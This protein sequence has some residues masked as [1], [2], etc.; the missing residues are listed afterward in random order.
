MKATTIILLPPIMWCNAINHKGAGNQ[1]LEHILDNK[2]RCPRNKK[3]RLYF[4]KV[5]EGACFLSEKSERH[6]KCPKS[7]GSAFNCA[8]G[9]PCRADQ[10]NPSTRRTD[11]LSKPSE[12]KG[13]YVGSLSLVNDS[14]FKLNV[15]D[16]SFTRKSMHTFLK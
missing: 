3:S 5:P 6:R 11:T 16:I 14:L 4:G 12:M 13:E 9:E 1:G 10:I 15:Y 7:Y 8:D 2:R